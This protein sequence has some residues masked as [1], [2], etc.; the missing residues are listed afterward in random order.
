MLSKNR[1]YFH[2]LEKKIEL[3]QLYELGYEDRNQRGRS[4][5]FLAESTDI[6]SWQALKG[7]WGKIKDSE[8]IA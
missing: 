7:N 2:I 1:T 8:T 6:E 5:I 3:S 4:S